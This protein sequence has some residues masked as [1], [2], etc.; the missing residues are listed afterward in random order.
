M[1]VAHVRARMWV[2]ESNGA[3]GAH[4]CVR[5]KG[6]EGERVCVRVW[7]RVSR[8]EPWTRKKTFS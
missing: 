7:Q 4:V 2:R 1:N 5:N 3:L 6:D 8:T